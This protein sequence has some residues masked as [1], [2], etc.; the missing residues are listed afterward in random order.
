VAE[1]FRPGVMDKLGL[2]YEAL[3]QRKPGLIYASASGYG[4]DGPYAEK[5]GQD[6]LAQALFGLM[7]ITGQAR[8]GPR[9]VGVS[10][11]DHH[12]AALFAM[13]I[14]AALVRRQRTG[15][16][17]RVDASLM[18]AAL[19]LQAE[20]LVA[21]LNAAPKPA[22]IHAHA[23]VAG[24]H[25]A[26]PYGVYATSDGHLA[27]SLSPLGALAEV[28]REPKLA[29]YAEK[30]TWTKKDE[31]GGLIAQAL[32]AATTAQWVARLEPLKIWHA[33]VQGYREVAADPQVGHMQSLVTVPGAG[34]T[35]APVTLL[36]HPVLY[37]GQTAA[38]RLPPQPLGAQ[39]REV[40]CE[41]GLT[42]AEI[43]SLAEARVI[44]LGS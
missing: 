7:A 29:T 40:L 33:P 17:C 41:I 35:G 19:D 32:A 31:I 1:N 37:D 5:P 27:L 13:G 34:D 42:A 9:P 38:V 6:L 20:S 2:G 36:N 25:Y 11:V 30:D 39:T 14:L 8:T 28:L 26:A 4:P 3:A 10:A 43:A 18:Q 21:W 24:W 15:R 12:G 22:A 16:G 44:K 23:H